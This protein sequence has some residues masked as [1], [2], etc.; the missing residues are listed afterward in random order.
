VIGAVLVN[1][2]VAKVPAQA[3]LDTARK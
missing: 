1:F 3:N 2:A